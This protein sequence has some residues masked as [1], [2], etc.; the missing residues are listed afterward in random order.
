M[1]LFDVIIRARVQ[2]EVL[3]IL[4]GLA[5]TSWILWVGCFSSGRIAGTRYNAQASAL[6]IP[7][8]WD[9]GDRTRY[10]WDPARSGLAQEKSV[11]VA[12][13]S[14]RLGAALA[15]VV[16]NESTLSV[17]NQGVKARFPD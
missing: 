12:A 11:F 4:R 1:G 16:R 9:P 8:K 17:G 15:V 13:H 2:L 6:A 7:S 3:V 10:R 5:H 14:T